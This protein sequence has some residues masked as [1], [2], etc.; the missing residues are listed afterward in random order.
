M[1]KPANDAAAL[2]AEWTPRLVRLCERLRAST[3]ETLL[4][5]LRRGATDEL[6]RPV[7]QGAGDVTYGLDVPTETL[8]S[9][10]LDEVSRET[11]ISLCTEDSGWRHRARGGSELDH[12]D[13]G[14][15]RIALD[16]IDG[17][18]NLMTNLRSAWTVVTFC[19]PGSETPRLSDCELGILSELPCSRAA[20]WRSLLA[21]RGRGCR[22]REVRLA[23]GAV[24]E[25]RPLVADT[26]DR[27]DHG[28]FP[29]FRYDRRQNPTITAIE[30]AFL[31]RLEAHEASDVRNCYDD[32][33]ISNGGQLALLAQ[34]TYRFI[35]DLRAWLAERRGERATTSKP[36]DCAGAIV[37]A[38]EAGA[39]V[40]AP[41]GEPLDF[42]IDTQTPVSFVGWANEATRARLSPHLRAALSA[43]CD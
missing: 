43:E 29:F 7:G 15:P 4:D 36:Y 5:A 18:R 40:T 34:G 3:R 9:Q 30:C 22:F 27:A 25:D 42:P 33:Y 35:A 2:V 6:A 23:D 13:H 41:E 20:T 14:G 11:A 38:L 8:C 21:E 37:C 12:F 10:W 16:P 24:L 19:G 39:P 26:D 31:E 32:Q 1:T 28:Y 17:T